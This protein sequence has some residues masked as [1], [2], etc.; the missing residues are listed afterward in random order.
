MSRLFVPVVRLF[1][2]RALKRQRPAQGLGVENNFGCVSATG[3]RLGVSAD[4]E[5]D[6]AKLELAMRLPGLPA[7]TGIN[8][9]DPNGT[10]LSFFG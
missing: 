2:S 1:A 3:Q 4:A 9:S 5:P 8:D 6:A 7:A 10:Y